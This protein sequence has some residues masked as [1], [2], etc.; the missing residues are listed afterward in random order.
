[1][2]IYTLALPASA[3]V[4]PITQVYTQ[5]QHPPVL[6][7]P[8][9][10]STLDPVSS[11]D[12]LISLRKVKRQCVH[13]ISSFCFYNHLSSHSCSFNISLDSISL[14]NTVREAL[15]HPGWRSAIVEEIQA[16]DGN[17]TWKLAQLPTRKKAIGCDWIF[18]VKV[19]HDR[20]IARLK[21][22]LVA[23]VYA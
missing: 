5:C 22:R 12:R 23:K 13:P 20:L 9:A 18:A 10:T 7:P 1:M 2:L 3:F 15:S 21:A 4:P 17:G 11:D 16:L 19:N 8:L 6:S 14:S